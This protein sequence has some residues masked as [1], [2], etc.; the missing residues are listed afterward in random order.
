MS[1]P[2]LR[3]L[4]DRDVLLTHYQTKASQVSTNAEIAIGLDDESSDFPS[5]V[6]LR[7]KY[8]RK[9]EDYVHTNIK[10]HR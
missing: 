3:F 10:Q 1:L 6:A 2:K 9:F 7:E 5:R 4:R 8:I